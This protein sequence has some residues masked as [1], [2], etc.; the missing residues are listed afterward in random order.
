MNKHLTAVLGL[1]PLPATLRYDGTPLSK[2]RQK[3][4]CDALQ[5]YEVGIRDIIIQNIGDL[6]LLQKVGIE[7]TT[8]MTMLSAAVRD[9]LPSDCSLGISVLMNDGAAAFAIAHAVGADYIRAK[10]YVGAMVGASGIEYGC[11]DEVLC[12]KQKLNSPVRIW[13][14]VHDRT[15]T[16]LGNPSL[17]DACEHALYKGLADVLIITGK[18]FDESLAM[19]SSVKAAFPNATVYLG[20]GAKPD[21]LQRCVQYSDGVI[22]GSY[23]KQNGV[24]HLPLDNQRMGEFMNAWRA[25]GERE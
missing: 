22:V 3:A 5:M 7:T 9:A 15:G 23:L 6:P 4:V 13:A 25:T 1:P 18:N 8:A 17:T 20:G 21:N 10:I 19:L 12:L 24:M 14:D 2:I 16:P 11:M